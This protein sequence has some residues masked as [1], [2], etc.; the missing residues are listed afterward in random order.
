MTME[1]TE[2]IQVLDAANRVDPT[3]FQWDPRLFFRRIGGED[4][5]V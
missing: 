5:D 2:K 4:G 1:T 3:V